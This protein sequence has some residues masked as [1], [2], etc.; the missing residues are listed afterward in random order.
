MK[1][2]KRVN[3]T[4]EAEIEIKTFAKIKLKYVYP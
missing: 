4:I 2:I 3:K 1:F